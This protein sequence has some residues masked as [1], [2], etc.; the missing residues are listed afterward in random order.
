MRTKLQR[1]SVAGCA[2]GLS[3]FS[4]WIQW[5]FSWAGARSQKP[6]RTG[7]KCAAV[8]PDSCCF[9]RCCWQ[10]KMLCHCRPSIVGSSPDGW[11]HQTTSSCSL[12]A[13]QLTRCLS[14]FSFQA[15]SI[16]QGIS[17]ETSRHSRICQVAW[18][19]LFPRKWFYQMHQL[20]VSL[21]VVG[22]F[23]QSRWCTKHLSR[24][25]LWPA[26]WCCK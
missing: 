21:F 13:L 25:L 9:C 17:A 5:W 7:K 24:S 16:I 26:R 23:H 8:C 4:V 18:A 2:K 11:M 15:K 22:V 1:S 6:R 14:T 10:R 20:S 12:F 19:V 3:A